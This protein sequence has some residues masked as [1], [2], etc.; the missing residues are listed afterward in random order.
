MT[1]KEVEIIDGVIRGIL[2][3]LSNPKNE[4]Y[5]LECVEFFQ[6]D[7]KKYVYEFLWE[8]MDAWSW[9]GKNRYVPS[10][11]FIDENWQQCVDHALM[12]LESEYQYDI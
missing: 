6:I 4:I 2:A 9:V 3:F 10:F 11:I 7:M 1:D 8:A 5:Y 12:I